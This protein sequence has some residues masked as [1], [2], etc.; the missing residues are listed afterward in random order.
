MALL[1]DTIDPR[2]FVQDYSGFARAG[3]IQANGMSSA[4]Q[5]ISGTVTDYTKEQKDAKLALKASQAQIDAAIQLF[6]SQAPY[7]SQIANELKDENKPLMDRAAAA[8][9]IAEMIN[10]SVGEKRYQDAEKWKERDYTLSLQDQ[11][12]KN[13]DA[14]TRNQIAQLQI[15]EAQSSLDQAAMDTKTKETLGAPLLDSVLAM[16]PNGIADGV[17]RNLADGNYTDAEKYS[18]ANSIMGLI[19]KKER[20]KAPVVQDVPVPGGTQKMQFDENSGQW[21]PLQVAP[22]SPTQSGDPTNPDLPIFTPADATDDQLGMVLPPLN[23][24]QA[25]A[26]QRV[27]FTPNTPSQAEQFAAE[28][29]TVKLEE[30]KAELETAQAA[31]NRTLAT[32]DKYLTP[33]GKPTQALNNAVGYGEGLASGIREWTGIPMN[34]AETVA[35]QKELN[36]SLIEAGLLEASKALKPVSNDE[37]K[38][39]KANRPVITDPPEVWAQYMKSLKGILG[40]PANYKDDQAVVRET[41]AE[42]LRAKLG[43]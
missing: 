35:N 30:K 28:D 25:A 33:D 22:M 26:Q 23:P 19:P 37:M 42:R 2:L 13:R 20:E 18:L 41:D 6:P 16:A 36:L 17:K 32:I 4:F 11:S 12:F 7:L 5:N 38:L 39:L 15:G 34:A 21:V 31:K 24:T 29:R 9:G 8:T 3:E 27:G 43:N 10:M 40:N 14:D 1:G